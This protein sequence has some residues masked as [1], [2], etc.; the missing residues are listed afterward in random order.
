MCKIQNTPKRQKRRTTVSILSVV[1]LATGFARKGPAQ[2]FRVSTAA[3]EK[4][5]AGSQSIPSLE[6]IPNPD[7]SGMEDVVL[8]QLRDARAGLLTLS[9]KPDAPVSQ[10][11]QAYGDM[12]MLY[13]AYGLQEGAKAC[14]LNAR[15]LAPHEFKWHYYLGYLYRT[16]GDFQKAVNCFQTAMEIRPDEVVLLRLAEANLDLEHTE[17]AK[18]LFE[19]VLSSS[20]SS[21]AAMTGL[22]KILLR[23]RDFAEAVRYLNQALALQPQASSIHQLLAVAYRGL[24]D[25]PQAQAHL[26]EQGQAVPIVPDP[27][28]DDLEKLKKG[29]TNLLVRARQAMDQGHFKEA[30]VAFR[31]IVAMLPD[32]ANSRANLGVALGQAGDVQEATAQLSEA[33][34]LAPDDAHAHYSLALLLLAARSEQQAMEHLQIAVKL[35]PGRKEAHFQLAN[36]LMRAKRYEEAEREYSQVVRIE[37]GNAAAR[38]MDAMASVRIKHYSQARDRLER[39]HK[40]LPDDFDIANAL[41]RLLAAS[42]EKDVRDGSRSLLL[43]QQAVRARGAMDVNQGQTLAMALAEVGQFT[44][45]AELQRS[46]LQEVEQSKDLDLVPTLRENLALYE[47]GQ[48]CRLPWRDD[49]PIFYPVPK[50]RIPGTSGRDSEMIVDSV[51]R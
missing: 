25:L 27:F 42:P 11:G 30:V 46:I 31:R 24:G 33:L 39:A 17:S 7:L 51:R 19:R 47:R 23:E 35:D 2:D 49:D 38:I 16:A 20:G 22:G 36:L 21:A 1:C 8:E 18:P 4:H 13:Q 40:I 15:T 43:I 34:R 3:T 26:L 6:P 41:A 32:D 10:L 48:A 50:V 9:Q 28:V 45:A 5:V 29:K 37:P 12:G 14:Y 44:R